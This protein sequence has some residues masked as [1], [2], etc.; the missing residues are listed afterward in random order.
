MTNLVNFEGGGASWQSVIY[1]R[2]CVMSRV[3]ITAAG[4]G[5][6]WCLL[7]VSVLMEVAGWILRCTGSYFQLKFSQLLPNWY[8][9]FTVQMV[10]TD[11]IWLM[12]MIW[13]IL[14]WLSLPRNLLQAEHASEGRK[15]YKQAAN[16]GSCS[17]DLP[18]ILKGEVWVFAEVHPF[19]SCKWF[20]LCNHTKPNILTLTIR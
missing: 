13:D 14:Q 18:Q 4:V 6:H 10:M 17:K 3:C 11:D 2:Q 20:F 1:N 15:T 19:H 12:E 7:T 9:C 8:N 5:G 16:R